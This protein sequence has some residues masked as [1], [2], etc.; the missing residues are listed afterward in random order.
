MSV[1]GA[2]QRQLS[3]PA[4]AKLNNTQH[5]NLINGNLNVVSVGTSATTA[6]DEHHRQR[7]LVLLERDESMLGVVRARHLHLLQ[8][9]QRVR[10]A[11]GVARVGVGVGHG[12]VYVI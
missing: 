2:Y 12:H 10:V 11:N 9:V 3:L 5:G 6:L 7:G 4:F 8:I 1:E